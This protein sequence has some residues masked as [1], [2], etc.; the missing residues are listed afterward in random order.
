MSNDDPQPVCMICG[1]YIT[2]EK[3]KTEVT[4]MPVQSETCYAHKHCI[5]RVVQEFDIPQI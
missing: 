1:H 3:E 5:G 4:V 2:D